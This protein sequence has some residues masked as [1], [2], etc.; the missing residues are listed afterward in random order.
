MRKKSLNK[1]CPKI[2]CEVEECNERDPKALHRHHLI[3]RSEVGTSNHDLNLVVLC[4]LHHTYTHIGR[5]K[6]IGI[7]PSTRGRMLV[8]ELDGKKN[9]EG[10]SGPYLELAPEQ[11]K[12]VRSKSEK[13][14]K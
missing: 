12:I 9:I 2:K 7:F 6:I 10:I 13:A 8:Y 11:M 1:L 5:L 4:P 14:A 3:H